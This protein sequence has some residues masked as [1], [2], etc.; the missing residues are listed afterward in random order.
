MKY[1]FRCVAIGLVSIAAAIAQPVPTTQAPLRPPAKSAPK[2]DAPKADPTKADA[3]GAKPP[4]DAAKPQE[5]EPAAAVSRGGRGT[6]SAGV[7]PK[8]LKFPPLRPIQTP[9]ITPLTLSNGMKLMLM[10]DHELP[11]VNGMAWTRRSA[12]AWPRLQAR[13]CEAGAP[14]RKRR[15][16]WTT[17][18][19]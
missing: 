19:K 12:S 8:D 9:N 6:T 13:C 3:P 4:E 2:T 7:L 15:T 16:R 5:G 14:P 18:W 11:M 10:E 17:C 1:P